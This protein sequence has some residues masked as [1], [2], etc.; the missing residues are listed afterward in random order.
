THVLADVVV[1]DEGE[2]FLAPGTEAVNVAP[3]T[4]EEVRHPVH[5]PAV[6]LVLQGEHADVQGVGDAREHQGVQAELLLRTPL[7]LV[8]DAGQ[9]GHATPRRVRTDAACPALRTSPSPR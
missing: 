7:V 2:H 9:R 6:E 1:V 5:R 8:E 3:A 4:L